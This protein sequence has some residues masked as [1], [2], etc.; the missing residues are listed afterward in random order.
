MLETVSSHLNHL[1]EPWDIKILEVSQHLGSPVL[2]LYYS[3]QCLGCLYSFFT[4]LP[5][6][7]VWATCALSLLLYSMSGPPVHFLCYSI[8]CLGHLC[9]FTTLPL[10]NVWI[11]CAPLLLTGTLSFTYSVL[12]Y[13]LCPLLLSRVTTGTHLGL[14]LC[15]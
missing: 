12:Y 2:V 5:L 8:Q 3:I 15:P 7:N 1:Q 11:T 10:L 4:T 9:S 6:L 13:L 14:V